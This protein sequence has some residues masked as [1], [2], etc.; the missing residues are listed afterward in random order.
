MKNKIYLIAVLMLLLA[1][2]CVGQNNLVPNGSFEDTIHC[3]FQVGQIYFATGWSSPNQGSSD[4]MNACSHNSSA[5]NVPNTCGGYQNART[6]N[7]M[8]GIATYY[9]GANQREYLQ[10]KLDSVLLPSH[11]YCVKFYV[12]LEDSQIV[13][14]NNIGLYFSD[15]AI[16]SVGGWLFNVN[17]QISNNN[18]TNPLTNK[19]G[20]TMV[21]GNFIAT[22][23]EQYITIGNFISDANSDTVHTVGGC[24]WGSGYF[25]D[26]VS[27]VDCTGEGVNENIKEELLTISPNPLTNFTTITLPTSNNQQLTTIT[28]TDVLGKQIKTL[29]F[30]SNECVIEKG[31]M[32]RGIYF[33]RVNSKQGIVNR[34]IVIQ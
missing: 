32:E 29:H 34:K 22:G 19:I 9:A 14:C 26:D 23:G 33:V 20:W 3:P 25:I 27:V 7:G 24:C 13:A 8:A 12:S 21:S 4:F 28:I 10:A 1:R 17:S 30:T 15:T 11:S 18:L 31:D 6:G 5:T 16:T 2:V